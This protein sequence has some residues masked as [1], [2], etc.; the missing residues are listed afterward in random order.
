MRPQNSE[1]VPFFVRV[2]PLNQLQ[3]AKFFGFSQS[4]HHWLP[5][6][7]SF[8]LCS[9]WKLVRD[10]DGILIGDDSLF[11]KHLLDPEHIIT[12]LIKVT[13][14][15]HLFS[16]TC[17]DSSCSSNFTLFVASGKFSPKNGGCINIQNR[18]FCPPIDVF[19]SVL[20]LFLVNASS[21]FDIRKTQ[22]DFFG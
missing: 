16:I 11:V 4:C 6:G 14:D 3:I 2:T 20:L 22:R 7:G 18:N 10:V 9:W 8:N 19:I 13:A 15:S 17:P 5:G 21:T 12:L 1:K